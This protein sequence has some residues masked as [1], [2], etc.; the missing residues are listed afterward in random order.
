MVIKY[1]F[2]GNSFHDSQRL[3]KKYAKFKNK[4]EKKLRLS[5]L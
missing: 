3:K 2:G 4:Y 5:E 1:F